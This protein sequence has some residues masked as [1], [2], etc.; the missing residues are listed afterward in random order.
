MEDVAYFLVIR[1]PSNKHNVRTCF[2]VDK[3]LSSIS[4]DFDLYVDLGSF[5]GIGDSK[6]S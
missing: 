3:R 5:D 4:K 2:P 6:T 1:L